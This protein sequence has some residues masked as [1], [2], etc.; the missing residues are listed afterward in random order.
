MAADDHALK[1]KSIVCF[2]IAPAYRGKGIATALLKRV[3]DD[4]KKDGY[5]MVE[6]Y[7]V[8]RDQFEPLD[9]TG[10]IHLYEKAGFVRVARQGQMVVMQKD[11]K[12]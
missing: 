2:E 9:F 11:L 10:P 12:G 3:C 7:P 4:A 5:D 8:V 1:I 6:A